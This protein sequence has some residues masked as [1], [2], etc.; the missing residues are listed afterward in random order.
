MTERKFNED[1]AREIM[2]HVRF[3]RIKTRDGNP[4]RIICWDAK[5]EKPIVVL[6][7]V[8]DIEMPMK[9]TINGKSDTRDYVSMNTDLV[10]ET[11]GGGA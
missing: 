6:V 1:T 8:G 5:G 2:A 7:D 9:Y 4:V 10:I 3:G 11:E